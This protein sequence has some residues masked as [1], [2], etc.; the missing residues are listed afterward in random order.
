MC[1]KNL[2]SH[3]RRVKALALLSL[4]SAVQQYTP[5]SAVTKDL[6]GTSALQGRFGV[7]AAK[8][9][10]Q[11]QLGYVS[12]LAPDAATMFGLEYVLAPRMLVK[13]DVPHR[14]VLGNFSHPVDYA[15]FG[16][17]RGLRV[18]EEFPRGV[19]LFERLAAQ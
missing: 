7:V 16:S 1:C 4:Y 8:L 5:S 11:T 18:V 2:F 15:A 6:Y 9:D 3:T 10:P 17:A 13:D 12:D 19:V 14:F